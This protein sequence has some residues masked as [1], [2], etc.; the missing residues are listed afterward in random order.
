MGA[1]ISTFWVR[2]RVCVSILCRISII[3]SRKSIISSRKSGN[4]EVLGAISRPV[5]AVLR[6]GFSNIWLIFRLF[7]GS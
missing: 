5:Q 6:G 7:R 3:F 1:A 4:L 2:F